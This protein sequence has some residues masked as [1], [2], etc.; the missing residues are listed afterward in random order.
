MTLKPC[1]RVFLAEATSAKALR[2]EGTFHIWKGQDHSKEAGSGTREVSGLRG[3]GQDL[4][5]E[6]R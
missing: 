6:W 3:G 1:M 2:Q 4:V 5:T